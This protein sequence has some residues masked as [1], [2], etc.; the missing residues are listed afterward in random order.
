MDDIPG[1]TVSLMAFYKG[2]HH[3]A[4]FLHVLA[5]V[6]LEGQVLFT[7]YGQYKQ[8]LLVNI[9]IGIVVEGINVSFE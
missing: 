1:V 9:F 8:N 7:T 4:K 5:S 6:T 3:L 2:H